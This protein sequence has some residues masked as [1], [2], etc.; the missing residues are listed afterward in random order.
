MK[1]PALSGMCVLQPLDSSTPKSW[2]KK[3]T[4]KVE[5]ILVD[6]LQVLVI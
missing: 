4:L 3:M 5:R 6:C 1:K 2:G